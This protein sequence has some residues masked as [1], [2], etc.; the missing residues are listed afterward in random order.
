MKTNID[1]L[2]LNS[3]VKLYLPLPVDK[4]LTKKLGNTE[5]GKF[6]LFVHSEQHVLWLHITMDN[7]G[8]EVDVVQG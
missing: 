6:N 8:Y 2:K 1:I 7:L 5:V 3:N 4:K